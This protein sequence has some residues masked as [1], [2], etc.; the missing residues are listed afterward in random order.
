M[1]TITTEDGTQIYFKDWGS[2]QAR[3]FQPW[4]A[5]YLG[6]FRRSNVLSRIAR[7]RC[8]AHDRRGHGRSSQ[9]WNGNDL[10]TYADDLAT[11]VEK[12]RPEEPVHV[13][14]STGGGEVGTLHR[15]PR[16]EASGEGSP[17][18]RDYPGHGQILGEVGLRKRP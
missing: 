8:V 4:L 16:L 1:N 14:H 15:A 12:A 13:G 17:Y 9:P 10:D 3:G 11:L 6:C 5:A 18:R 7:Y 2:G